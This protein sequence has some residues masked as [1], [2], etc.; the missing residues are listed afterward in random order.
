[1]LKKILINSLWVGLMAMVLVSCGG[2][3]SGYDS[4][5][6]NNRGYD[7]ES[8]PT[9]LAHASFR[10][11]SI[12]RSFVNQHNVSCISDK[13]RNETVIIFNDATSGSTLSVRMGRVDLSDTTASRSYNV[14][15]NPGEDS[16]LISVNSDKTNGAYRLVYN[17]DAHYKPNCQINYTLNDWQMNGEFLC[18]SMTNRAG[19]TQEA[20]GEWSCKLQSEVQWQW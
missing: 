14:E 2:S 5:N 13:E 3:N 7:Y 6:P 16:F 9:I 4:D 17:S 1:M 11:G 10:I 20:R 18:Y 8:G 15:A 19:Q 12:E